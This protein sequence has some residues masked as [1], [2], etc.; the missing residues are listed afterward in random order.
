[1]TTERNC[2]SS[3]EP[4]QS[5]ISVNKTEI[6]VCNASVTIATTCVQMSLPLT[7]DDGIN[8]MRELCDEDEAYFACD[9]PCKLAG[10]LLAKFS[11]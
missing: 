7:Y 2:T 8:Q 1:M 4:D 11:M 10:V 6:A 5:D 3:Y 9:V